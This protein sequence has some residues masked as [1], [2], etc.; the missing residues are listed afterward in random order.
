MNASE[1]EY[2]NDSIASKKSSNLSIASKKSSKLSNRSS[3]KVLSR[4]NES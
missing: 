2:F 1:Q 3:R 4:R